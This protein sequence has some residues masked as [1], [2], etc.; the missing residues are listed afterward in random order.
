M[1]WVDTL[2]SKLK[3]PVFFYNFGYEGADTIIKAFQTH[4]GDAKVGHAEELT[5]LF[6]QNSVHLRGSDTST[7]EILIDL[8]TSFAI[9]GKPTSNL[10]PN[11]DMWTPY[12]DNMSYLEISGSLNKS[13][14]EVILKHSYFPERMNF[15][16]K[17]SN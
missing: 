12:K 10:L 16:K 13:G 6:P 4:S 2:S 3:S 15:W 5:Y 17:N 8:W 11:P 1:K 7:S 14:P 9:N